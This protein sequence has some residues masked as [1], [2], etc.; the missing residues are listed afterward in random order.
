MTS[1]ITQPEPLPLRARYSGVALLGLVIA[2]LAA[3]VV[4]IA[5][6]CNALR[7]VGPGSQAPGFDLPTI[8]GDRI[9]LGDLKGRVVLIDFWSVT[10]SPCWKGLSHL[11]SVQRRFAGEPVTVLSIHVQATRRAA[12][13]AREAAAQLGLRFPVLLDTANISDKYTV[14]VL[15]TIVLIDQ[16]GRVHKVWRGVTPTETL[17]GEIESLLKRK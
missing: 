15:P 6:N 17:V 5:R 2:L 9:R 12:E 16:K 3:N 4:W 11:K 13:R 1:R 14:R 7:S 8:A 10:C